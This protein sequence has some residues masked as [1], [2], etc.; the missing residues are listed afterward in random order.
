MN[1]DYGNKECTAGM[2]EGD[3][4]TYIHQFPTAITVSAS[5]ACKYASTK[6]LIIIHFPSQ[7]GR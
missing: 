7:S 6:I 2:K 3:A 1:C 5:L 4:I